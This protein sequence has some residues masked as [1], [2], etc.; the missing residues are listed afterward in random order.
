MLHGHA[1]GAI[2][3]GDAHLF[4]AFGD[5]QFGDAGFLNEIDQLLEF[6]QIH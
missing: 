6:A 4:L 1:D 2:V 3:L 5:F